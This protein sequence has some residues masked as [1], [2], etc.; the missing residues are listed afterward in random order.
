[1]KEYFIQETINGK[2]VI[3]KVLAE[4]DKSEKISAYDKLINLKTGYLTENEI[5][6]KNTKNIKCTI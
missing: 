2:L 1:M 3:C 6:S 5:E 4:F